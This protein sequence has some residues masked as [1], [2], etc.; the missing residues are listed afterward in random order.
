MLFLSS[1]PKVK[2]ISNSRL[3]HSDVG[4]LNQVLE[5]GPIDF[6][7]LGSGL[8]MTEASPQVSG[9]RIS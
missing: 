4:L 7:V 6:P 1:F 8:T 3:H 9:T 5:I 2:L